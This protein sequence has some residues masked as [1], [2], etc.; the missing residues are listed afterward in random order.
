MP[1]TWYGRNLRADSWW[2]GST[3]P[4]VLYMGLCSAVPTADTTGTTMQDLEPYGVGSYARIAVDM[5]SSTWNTSVS[6]IITNKVDLE[7]A[8]PT[9]AW[10]SLNAYGL[11]DAISEGNLL[12][13]GSISTTLNPTVG[14]SL[15]IPA[16]Q[17]RI[18]EL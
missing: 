7:F 16:E 3:M 1:L 8:A 10:G 13:Y 6:G 11:C 14:R 2:D 17:L 9:A 18:R 4:T 12:M 5:D 15:V